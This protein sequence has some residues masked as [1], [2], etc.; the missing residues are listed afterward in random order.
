MERRIGRQTIRGERIELAAIGP[1][2]QTTRF[3]HQNDTTCH[4]PGMIVECPVTIKSTGGQVRQVEGGRTRSPQRLG[5]EGKLPPPLEGPLHSLSVR[6][7]PGRQQ[8]LVECLDGANGQSF[9]VEERPTSPCSRE[10]FL[11]PRVEYDA[12]YQF[13]SNLQ[14]DRDT[15]HWHV[16]NIVGGAIEWIDNPRRW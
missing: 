3:A 16:M 8:R 12:D 2:H 7:K 10:H 14:S 5:V 1:R 13:A 4:V 11:L 9:A 15:I 6:R